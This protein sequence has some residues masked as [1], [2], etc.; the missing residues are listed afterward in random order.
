VESAD[1]ERQAQPI[2]N[3][4][5]EVLPTEVRRRIAA[6]WETAEAVATAN[7]FNLDQ[8]RDELLTLFQGRVVLVINEEQLKVA[9]AAVTRL[10]NTA[11]HGAQERGYHVLAPFFLNEALFKLQHLYPLTD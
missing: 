11:V 2:G 8:V 7:E 6:M 4:G 5:L 10:M 3:A 9:C 1:D